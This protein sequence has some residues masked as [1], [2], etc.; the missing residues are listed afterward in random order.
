M[1]YY[2]VTYSPRFKR[3]NVY[4][5]GC[6]FD[7]RGCSYKLNPP[8]KNGFLSVEQVEQVL[9]GLEL[10]RVHFLGGEPS[11]NPALPRLAHFARHK[12]GVHTKLGH[13][14]GSAMP[15]QDIE[16]TSVSIKALTEEIHLQYT[17]VS[18]AAVL[19]NF[20]EAYRRGIRVDASSVLIPDLIDCDE[21]EMIAR[22]IAEI[23][24]QIPYHITGYA[25]VPGAPWRAPTHNEVGQAVDVA[26][27]HLAYVTH[28]CLSVEDFFHL[29]ALDPR[30]E[31]IR[32]A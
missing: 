32:V 7:C 12:L 9:Q 30:Y 2:K 19:E 27:R 29:E 14:N 28:S 17:G 11:A 26:K 4:N 31:S 15:P 18:N 6:N 1:P 23:D 25:P 8:K 22:F 3:A 20:A 16:A 24:P 10:E 21:I 5:W 13:S